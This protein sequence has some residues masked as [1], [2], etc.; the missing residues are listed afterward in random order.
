MSWQE[1][2]EAGL[3]ARLAAAQQEHPP[4][5]AFSA[6]EPTGDRSLTASPPRGTVT[7]EAP[8]EHE[9]IR[10]AREAHYTDEG[11]LQLQQFMQQH[12]IADPMVAMLAFEQ[13]NPSPEPVVSGATNWN[14]FDRRDK[15]ADSAA[16]E[17]LL[18]GDY[19]GFERV[20]IPAAL[21][22]VRGR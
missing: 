11:A 1:R 8:R 16:Y 12:S 14:F 3:R 9:V 17:M 2:I 15:G 5:A 21:N 19:E 20:A 7:R 22:E 4:A 10:I 6:V 18:K 13:L